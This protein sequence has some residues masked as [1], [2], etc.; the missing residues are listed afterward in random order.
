MSGLYIKRFVDRLQQLELAGQKE[1]RCPISDAKNLHND[2]T[3]LLA[4][5]QA[6]H[7][8]TTSADSSTNITEIEVTGGSF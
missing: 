4:D 1:F 7:E 6:L 2:I 5:I 8:G 3:K